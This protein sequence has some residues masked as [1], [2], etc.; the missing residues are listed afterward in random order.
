[1]R[2]HFHRWQNAPSFLAFDFRRTQSRQIH[3][4]PQSGHNHES[5]AA[6]HARHFPDSPD[7]RQAQTLT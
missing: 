5:G 3:R 6:V 7:A 1:M 4:R 2:E